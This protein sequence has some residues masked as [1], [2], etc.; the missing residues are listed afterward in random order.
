[1]LLHLSVRPL[2]VEKRLKQCAERC[3]GFGKKK[4]A[5]NLDKSKITKHLIFPICFCQRE[6]IFNFL[7]F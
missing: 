6:I 7:Q 5:E 3:T 2:P 1:M 4:I